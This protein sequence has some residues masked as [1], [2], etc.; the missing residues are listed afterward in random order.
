VEHDSEGAG[1][2]TRLLLLALA[3]AALAVAQCGN[4]VIMVNSTMAVFQWSCPAAVNTTYYGLIIGA[5]WHNSTH[6]A[7]SVVDVTG[8]NRSVWFLVVPNGTGNV[9]YNGFVQGRV[10]V[11]ASKYATQ[12][13]VV[14]V[15][16]PTGEDFV[17][18]LPPAVTTALPAELTW[19]SWAVPLAVASAFSLRAKAEEAAAGL[20]VAGLVALPISTYI[21]ANP[22]AS[23]LST[24]AIVVG[25]IILATGR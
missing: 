17:Y 20:I 18:L 14:A 25:V 19:L 23:V 12:P 6:I 11:N 3:L 24:L 13:I 21:V 9:L 1:A 5:N 10:Y 7:L 4:A 8:Q 22:I 15:Y 16:M 2:M